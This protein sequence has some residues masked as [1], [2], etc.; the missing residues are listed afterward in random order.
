MRAYL[1]PPRVLPTD[2]GRES[3]GERAFCADAS[4]AGEEDD[5]GEDE[6]GEYKVASAA[7]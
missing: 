4:A 3:D 5:D 6:V 1:V 2:T 7:A